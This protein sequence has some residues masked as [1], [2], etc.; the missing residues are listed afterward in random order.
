VADLTLTNLLQCD[1]WSSGGELEALV[2]RHMGLL[3]SKAIP[4]A[5]DL[6]PYS[7]VTVSSVLP[8]AD[9]CLPVCFMCKCRTH[10]PVGLCISSP[11]AKHQLNMGALL[12]CP[13]WCAGGRPGDSRGQAV[14][15]D[16]EVRHEL[17]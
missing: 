8:L 17:A 1:A 11:C 6:R 10:A 4:V 9:V 3:T 7:H 5:W 16:E 2:L 12:C 13:L 15:V 14:S